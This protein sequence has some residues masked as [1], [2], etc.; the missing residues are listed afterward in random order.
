MFRIIVSGCM[1][2]GAKVR[3]KIQTLLLWA[4]ILPPVVGFAH[5]RSLGVL[6][7][8]VGDGVVEGFGLDIL[9]DAGAV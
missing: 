2:E 9:G 1:V 5:A 8:Q 4:G 6:F 7:L 3:K